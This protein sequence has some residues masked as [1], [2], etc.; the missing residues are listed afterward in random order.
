M[1]RSGASPPE[2]RDASREDPARRLGDVR[3]TVAARRVAAGTEEVPGRRAAAR[4]GLR[5]NETAEVF[6]PAAGRAPPHRGPGPADRAVHGDEQAGRGE[7]VAGRAGEV[8]QG[9]PAG[10]RE[11]VSLAE[12]R[13]LIPE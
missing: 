6:D 4:Q 10:A 3:G 1:V 8:P 13:R 2:V 11:E 7:E 12:S 5:G 9:R